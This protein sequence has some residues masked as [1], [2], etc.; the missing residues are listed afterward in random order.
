MS[1]TATITDQVVEQ[2]NTVA[3]AMRNLADVKDVDIATAPR[4]VVWE[5]GKIRLFHFLRETP[6]K[7][8]TPVLIS[9]ALVNR[10]EMMD[11]QPN[12]SFIR[13]LLELGMDVYVIDWGYASVV[14]RYK[15]MEDYILGNIN[16]C[17][18]FL[19]RE[20]GQEAINLLGVCQG[21]TFSLMYSAL[22][23]EKIKN[24][25]TLVTPVDFDNEEGLLFKWAKK[26]DVDAIVD[27]FGGVVPGDFL[28]T[29]FDLL[30]PMNKARK[31]LALPKTMRRPDSLMNFL[32]MEHWVADSP[33]QAGDTYRR[34]IKD[35]YQENKLIKGTFAL[36]DHRVDL[37]NITMPILTIYAKDDHIVPPDTTKPINKL[38][39][40]KDKELME[41]PGGHIGV[42]VGS[43]SQK[44]LT[45]AVV[46]W[47]LARD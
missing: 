6:P 39:G 18:D 28:N 27:G 33:A 40:S 35:M 8:K 36:D 26:L 13:K 46:D 24:L 32:R 37:A 12:R 21:G 14:D 30:K 3:D 31:Y 2:V 4:E 44:L 45:P 10:W 23:P 7:A 15:T 5:D 29:G 47:Y 34:F 38:V 19:R 1:P 42:F 20:S 41:F 43:R 17:V 16:D 11:L 9:Y 25:V 22:F